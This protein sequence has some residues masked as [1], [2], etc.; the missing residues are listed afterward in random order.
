MCAYVSLLVFITKHA[1][2][3][4]THLVKITV[5]DLAH[6]GGKMRYCISLI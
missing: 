6:P 4:G 3:C 5:C 2:I 1:Y